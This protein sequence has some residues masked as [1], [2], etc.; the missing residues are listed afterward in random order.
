MKTVLTLCWL[1]LSLNSFA[2]N[3]GHIILQHTTDSNGVQHVEQAPV[4]GEVLLEDYLPADYQFDVYTIKEIYEEASWP[5]GIITAER[6]RTKEIEKLYYQKINEFGLGYNE[7]K[8]FVGKQVIVRYY[9][10][11]ES[12]IIVKVT[13]I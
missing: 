3:R 10:N 12:K 1:L 6:I 11:G 5:Y 13:P 4:K 8:V 7:L 2:Q 9:T